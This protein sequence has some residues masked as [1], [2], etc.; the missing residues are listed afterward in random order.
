MIQNNCFYTRLPLLPAFMIKSGS[1]IAKGPIP[2][3]TVKEKKRDGKPEKGR[4]SE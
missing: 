2:A 3:P 1:A 4:Y